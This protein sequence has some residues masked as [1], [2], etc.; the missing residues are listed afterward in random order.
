MKAGKYEL[1]VLHWEQI[2][3]KPGQPF[4]FV[5]HHRGDVVDLN[6]EDARRLVKAGAVKVPGA[7]DAGTGPSVPPGALGS[8]TGPT[9][10]DDVL[11]AVGDDPVK[12][13]EALDLEN[14][15]AKPR[16]TLVAKLE[17]IIATGAGA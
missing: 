15:A 4:D 16:V 1:L 12:A 7:P 10:A 2:L 13:Q 8:G 5:R 6:I 17:A 11:A 14:A 9:K 3:S